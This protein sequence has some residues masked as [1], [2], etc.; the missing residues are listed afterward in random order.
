MEKILK[1]VILYLLQ[2]LLIRRAPPIIE[3]LKQR[4]GFKICIFKYL[5]DL[6][7]SNKEKKKLSNKFRVMIILISSIFL[8]Y[9]SE[10]ISNTCAY[11]KNLLHASNKFELVLNLSVYY[12][13]KGNI[14]ILRKIYHVK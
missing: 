8:L 13:L 2:E 7:V 1:E 12:F 6:L 11:S 3:R 14:V 10:E 4:H 5:S 9:I